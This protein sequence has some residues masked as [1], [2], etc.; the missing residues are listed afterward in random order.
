MYATGNDN[1]HTTKLTFQTY[2]LR[3]V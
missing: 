3:T 1:V 2:H